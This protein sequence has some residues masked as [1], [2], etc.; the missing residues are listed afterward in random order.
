MAMESLST[1][2]KLD[3]Q[4]TLET[5]EKINQALDQHSSGMNPGKDDIPAEVIRCAKGTLLKELYET[6]CQCWR[7][8]EVLQDMRTANIVILYKNKGDRV[9]VTITAASLSSTSLEKSSPKLS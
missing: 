2:D 7:E 1:M 8:G 4:P 6:L 9:T 3:S 5:L